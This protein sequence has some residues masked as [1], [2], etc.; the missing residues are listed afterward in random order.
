MKYHDFKYLLDVYSER[1]PREEGQEHDLGKIREKFT[2]IIDAIGIDSS[3][4]K[5]HRDERNGKM[6][7]FGGGKPQFCFPETVCDFCVEIILRY[8]SAD[9]KKIRSAEFSSV[10][11]A[12]SLFLIDGFKRYLS[13]LGHD[14]FTIVRQVWKMD[15]RLHHHANVLKSE[16]TRACG[17]LADCAK[18][19][20]QFLSY[21]DSVYFIW[22]MVTR[23]NYLQDT[24]ESIFSEYESARYTEIGDIARLHSLTMD[25]YA[26]SRD[27]FQT[28]ALAD[29][30]EKDEDYQRLLKKRDKILIEPGFKQNSKGRYNKVTS[31]ISSI[32]KKHEMELF[33]KLISEDPHPQFDLKHPTELLFDATMAIDENER[34]RIEREEKEAALT[35]EQIKQ[36]EESIRLLRE[37][38]ESR[39]VSFD[40]PDVSIEEERLFV[41][42]LPDHDEMKGI[43]KFPCCGKERIMVYSGSSGQCAVKCPNCGKTSIFNFK[44]MTAK[45]VSEIR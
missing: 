27:F 44:E 8:T 35:E 20:E 39:G 18:N 26:A 29:I 37:H 2:E 21:E 40:L 1:K 22:H 19:Y 15:R 45:A 4:L 14:R 24:I 41:D 34:E 36:R 13:D 25:Q 5:Q 33:G 32:R 23:V 11:P 31:E 38:Y 6:V 16:L 10:N 30:L 43:I 3:L 9:F 7:K 17:E 12:V 42:S 28:I